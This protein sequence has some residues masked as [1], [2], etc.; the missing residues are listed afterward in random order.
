[1]TTETHGAGAPRPASDMGWYVGVL[2]AA[3]AWWLIYGQLIPFSEW[4]TSLFPVDRRSHTGEA[5]AFFIYDVPK[6]CSC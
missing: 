3:L 4:A 6:V 5:L 2:L 1:M